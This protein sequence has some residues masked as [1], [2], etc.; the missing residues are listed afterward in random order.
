MTSKTKTVG[1][2]ARP[3]KNDPTLRAF[4]QLALQKQHGREG[5]GTR[6]GK[7]QIP[8][9]APIECIGTGSE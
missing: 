5:W 4:F 3:Y 1:A 2:K 9:A 6:K 7:Q 8:H